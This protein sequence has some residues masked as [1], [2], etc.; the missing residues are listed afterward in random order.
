MNI[1]Y[2]KT[3]IALHWVHWG[4]TPL[5]KEQEYFTKIGERKII[6]KNIMTYNKKEKEKSRVDP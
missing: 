1:L 5:I 3:T 4:F 6:E 2:K